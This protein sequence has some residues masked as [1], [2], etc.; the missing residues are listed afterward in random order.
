MKGVF[1]YLSLYPGLD[2]L[3]IY[4]PVKFT[5]ENIQKKRQSHISITEPKVKWIN[6]KRNNNDNNDK[7]DMICFDLTWPVLPWLDLIWHDIN[8][9]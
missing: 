6:K 8:V 4:I 5:I 7:E 9:V 2:Y 1:F 3:F